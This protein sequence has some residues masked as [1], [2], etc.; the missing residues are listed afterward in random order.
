MNEDHTWC[1]PPRRFKVPRLPGFPCTH[2]RGVSI[3]VFV[4]RQRWPLGKWQ[5]GYNRRLYVAG[6]TVCSSCNARRTMFTFSYARPFTVDCQ[7]LLNLEQKNSVDCKN[8]AAYQ[9]VSWVVEEMCNCATNSMLSLWRELASLVL[10][11]TMIY[12]YSCMNICHTIHCTI[13]EYSSTL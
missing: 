7:Y 3:S 1:S 10:R 9:H 8:I 4:L 12:V 11:S 13:L 2:V 6:T 5:V